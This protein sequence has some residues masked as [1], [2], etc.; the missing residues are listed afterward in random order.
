[1]SLFSRSF[2]VRRSSAP[3]ARRKRRAVRAP[4]TSRGPGHLSLAAESLERRALLAVSA[5]LS[6]GDLLIT[7]NDPGDTVADIT[8]D[9]TDYTV[10]GTGLASTT[11]KIADVTGVISV[12]DN[13]AQGGQEF[14]VLA[15]TVLANPLQINANVE[16]ATLTGGITATTAGDVLIGSAAITL[17][18]DISTAATNANIAFTGAVTLAQNTTLNAGAGAITFKSTVDG[19]YTLTA[20]STGTTTFGGVV[21]GTGKL[22]SLTTNAGGTASLLSVSTSGAQTYNDDTV[23]LNGTYAT[24]DSKFTV[25]KNTTLAGNT[26]VSTG[27]GDISFNGT[28]DG[29]YTLAANSTGTTTFGGVVGGT[30]KLVSLTTNAGGTA[31]LLSVSTSGAQT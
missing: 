14:K 15:G 2:P 13:A 1:M 27:T 12:A 23:T 6:G 4:A 28:V 29:L 19:A 17:A 5:T 10:T 11:F 8:S 16:I 22:V 21:G 31:S 7:Y 18:N 20:N 24:T 9:G 30:G 3:P 25:D 26:V